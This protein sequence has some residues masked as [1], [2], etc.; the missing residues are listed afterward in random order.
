MRIL[1]KVIKEEKIRDKVY[2]NRC[3]REID[4]IFPE[5]MGNYLSVDKRWGYGSVYD[6]ESHSFDLCDSCYGEI[7]R[8]FKIPPSEEN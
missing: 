5:H 8:E 6:G 7:V 3:G 1:K 4:I 2:C